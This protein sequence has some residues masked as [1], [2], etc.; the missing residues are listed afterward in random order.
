MTLK[1]FLFKLT[2]VWHEIH[3][4]FVL[5]CCL[6]LDLNLWVFKKYKNIIWKKVL[7]QK[8]KYQTAIYV[9]Y[10]HG[11]FITLIFFKINSNKTKARAMCK[12]YTHLQRPFE[13]NKCIWNVMKCLEFITILRQTNDLM[14]ICKQSHI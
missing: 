5:W 12:G 3:S 11:S 4:L 6:Y 1:L 2:S 10:G 14:C 9:S 13:E 8:Y 7:L